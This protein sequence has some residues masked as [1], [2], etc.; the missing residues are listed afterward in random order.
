MT[1]NEHPLTLSDIIQRKP[2]PHPWEEGDKIPWNDPDFSRRMLR[3]HLSQEHDAASRRSEI[4]DRQVAWIQHQLLFERR[5]KILDLGCGPGLYTSRLAKF[6]HDC[7]G[8]DFGPASIAYARETARA[9]SLSCKYQLQDIR[10]AEY[11]ADYD[12]VM[13]IFGEFNVFRPQDAQLI[14]TKAYQ[15][16]KPGGRLLLEV[17]PFDSTHQLGTSPA[18]W[19]TSP[20]G[21]FSD[22]PYLCLHEHFWDAELQVATERYFVIDSDTGAV[23]RYAFST[24]AYHEAEY[25]SMLE[26]CDFRAIRFYPA[27]NAEGE[28]PGE[29]QVIVAHK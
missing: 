13:F 16:L 17:D 8:I 21:L 24:Q 27:S 28:W 14:L 18:T 26:A 5:G 25:R 23:T 12:L 7:T 4:I 1:E 11:G 22:Q 2:V 15:A 20:H 10:S 6:G 9:E 29:F 3:E 19:Y